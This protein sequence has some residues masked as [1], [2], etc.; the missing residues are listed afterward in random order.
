MATETYLD[1]WHIFRDELIG[2]TN[3][4]I[5]A[6]AITIW[7]IGSKLK[8]PFEINLMAVCL[9]FAII[10]AKTFNMLIWATL[11]IL[12]SFA[13]YYALKQLFER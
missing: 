8:F 11:G 5:I 4:F 9:W 6:G 10:F 12:A 1:F 13:F 2:D 3:L 7:F